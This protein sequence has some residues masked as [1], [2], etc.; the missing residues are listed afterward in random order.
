MIRIRCVSCFAV[1]LVLP[2]LLLSACDS[3]GSS[4]IRLAVV[5]Q[6]ALNELP[7]TIAQQLGYFRDQGLSVTIDDV[8]GAS[9][10]ID[11][12]VGG[13]ADVAAGIFDT[14]VVAASRG[15]PLRSFELMTNSP[16]LVLAV[17]PPMKAKI[18]TI[19]DLRGRTVGVTTL[20]ASTEILVRYIAHKHGLGEQD[21]HFV[22]LGP[23]SARLASMEKGLVDA[24]V[25][26]E[27]AVSVLSH[28]FGDITLLAD[29]RTGDGMQYS[30]GSSEYPGTVVFA[31]PQWLDRNPSIAR[32][33]TRALL[34]AQ[35]WLHEHSSDEIISKIPSSFNP[36]QVGYKE[37]LE[38]SIPSYTSDGMFRKE[39][40]RKAWEV[41]AS[42]SSDVRDHP[43]AWEGTY[44]NE[45]ITR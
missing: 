8:S 37:G 42:F 10:G 3:I 23:P 41:L 17:S 22:Q 30:Y 35:R 43:A 14:L 31:T 28:K 11:S 26:S 19:E 40:A 6:S 2:V 34:L 36:S 15:K 12:V 45:F 33:L 21:I 32:K 39:A 18:R 13:S 38:A 25:I 5:S 27:P 29:T 20:G 24:A 7:V 16:G 4:K 44:T 9:G 1:L